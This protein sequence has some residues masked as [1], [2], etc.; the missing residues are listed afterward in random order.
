MIVLAEQKKASVRVAF[1]GKKEAENLTYVSADYQAVSRVG[2]LDENLTVYIGQGKEPLTIRNIQELSAGAAGAVKGMGI[3]A[4]EMDIRPFLEA[5]GVRAVSA[6]IEGIYTGAYEICL[7]GEEPKEIPDVTLTG[8]DENLYPAAQGELKQGIS[9]A[10]AQ[11]WARNM[12]NAPGNLF[13]PMDFAREIMEH[14]KET[15][16]ECE[17]I[18]YSKLNAMGMEALTSVGKSS[19]NPPCMLVM[20]YRGDEEAPVT[21]L[22]GKGVTCDTGGIHDGDQRRYGRRCGSCGGNLC[23]CGK[24]GQGQCNWRNPDV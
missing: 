10:E 19:E 21:G 9:L 17:L 8:I 4:Y 5:A 11:S 1:I 13:H 20:R 6:V 7:P 15:S 12:V 22:V 2:G 24:S 18:V 16:V 3:K 14:M 23:T